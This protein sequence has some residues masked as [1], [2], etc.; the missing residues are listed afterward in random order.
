MA[1]NPGRMM[2]RIITAAVP[3]PVLASIF[4]YRKPELSAD[5]WQDEYKSSAWEYLRSVR[6]L[7]RFS[8]ILGY[9]RFYRPTGRILE[10]GCGEGL[11]AEGLDGPT[12]PAYLGVDIS[13]AAIEAA[14]RRGCAH[15]SFEVADVE[16]Y[17]PPER[18]QFD[19]VIFNEML[20]Y[21]AAPAETVHR[22]AGSL[23]AEGIVIV[24]MVEG[25]RS[26][27]VWSMLRTH[28]NILDQVRVQHRRLAWRIGVLRPRLVGS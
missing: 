28:F 17:L 10:L 22:Y 1:I 20:F 23:A 13:D 9:C 19:I 4:S 2:K 14:R 5:D 21:L 26:H 24:S 15:A 12:C 27:Q 25:V 16:L 11:I 3:I 7:A 6:E 8:V 18:S